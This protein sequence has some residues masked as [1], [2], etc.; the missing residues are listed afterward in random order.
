MILVVGGAGYVGSHVNKLLTKNKY[1]TI[2]IDNLIRGH[3]EFLKWGE[4]VFCD[5]NNYDQIS[6]VFKK[7]AIKAVMHFAA[8]AYV[9][10]SV[11][12]PQKYYINNVSNCINL[13]KVMLE[14]NVKYFIFSSSCAIYG[15]P[16]EIPITENFPLN[17]VNPYGRSK[18]MIEN[19]LDSYYKAYGLKYVSLRYFNAAGADMEGEI[20]EWHEPETHLI[21]RILDTAIRKRKTISIYGTDYNTPDGTCVRD[22]IHVIDLA[23]AHILAL[24]YL[25][26]EKE[27]NIFNLGNGDGF[28]VKETIRIARKITN[29]KINTQ[30]CDKRVGDPPILISSAEKAKK[31]LNW[32]PK[33]SDLAKII[34]SAW[35]WHIK[36]Q[37]ILRD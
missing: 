35:N 32:Q 17:P 21:P 30:E 31:I 9:E 3:N 25:M 2:V 28:S 22:F 6:L 4:F 37:E 16:A 11:K 33:F 34:E 23:E 26:T 7:Y 19:I 5:L 1:N 10:E 29:Q 14:N 36:L 27:C 18:F 15:I 24:Q 13:L 20:G 12:D 8:F